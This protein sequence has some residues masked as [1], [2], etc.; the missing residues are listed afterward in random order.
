MGD[1]HMHV[2]DGGTRT[3]GIDVDVVRPQRHRSTLVIEMMPALLTP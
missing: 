1:G 2:G 3:D